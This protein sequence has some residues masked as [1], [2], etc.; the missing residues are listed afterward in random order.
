MF[1]LNIWWRRYLYEVSICQPHLTFT[2][3]EYHGEDCMWNKLFG[4][5]YHKKHYKARSVSFSVHMFIYNRRFH[6]CLLHYLHAWS[7]CSSV[8]VSFCSQS[9]R[10]SVCLS[11]ILSTRLICQFFCLCHL[12]WI[13]LSVCLSTYCP[14][15]MLSLSV[16]CFI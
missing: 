1:V 7:V 16:I 5:H 3:Q 11:V 13:L 12:Q 4:I 10:V 8:L 2:M 14:I 9:F 15:C 6:I